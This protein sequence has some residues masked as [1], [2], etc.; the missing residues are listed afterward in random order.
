MKC[1]IT[2]LSLLV[3]L[4]FAI[5][6]IPS[7]YT[8]GHDVLWIDP[9]V[10]VT[11]NQFHKSSQYTL[12]SPKNGTSEGIA[13]ASIVGGA[14][15]RAHDT[16]FKQNFVPWK[17]YTRMSDFEPRTGK[18]AH[19][20][21]IT[22]IELQQ[23]SSDPPNPTNSKAGQL[24]ESYSLSV[25]SG[26]KVSI[27]AASS[28]GLAHGL[29]TFTQLFYAHSLGG[30][31]TPLAPVSI[32]DSPKFVH[33]GL[34][35]D[36]ARNFYPVPSILRTI[37][38]LAYNKFNRLHLHI[39]DAQ[40]WPLEVPALPEL[41]A[42]GA[43]NPS[44]IYHPDDIAEMQ[45]FGALRG[46]QVYLETDMPGHTSS[47]AY[48]Y[49]SLIAAFNIQPNWSS[50]AVEPPSG[51]LKLNSPAVDQFIEKLFADILPRVSASTP[52]FH[53]GGD[54]VDYA[55][56]EL[57]PTVKSSDPALLKPLLQKFVNAAHSHVRAAGLI[58]MAW[59][60]I[61]L[62]YNLTLGKDV[63]VQSWVSA[64]SVAQ[65]TEKGYKVIAGSSDYWYLDCGHGQF[66]NFE[67]G[68]VSQSSWPYTDYCD[69]FKN[70][71]VMYSYDPL[72]GITDE[73]AQKLVLGGEAHV[74]SEQID[75]TSLDS[76]IWPRLGAA[77]EVLWSGAKDPVTGQN[78]SQI[79][80][81]PRLSE[82]RER[83]IARGVNSGVI[84]MPFCTQ[85]SEQ[86]NEVN[87]VASS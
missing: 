33:R 35:L 25:T 37:D 26:G 45:R 46:V 23:K 83:L 16:I 15:L 43:Y 20:N 3:P 2:C 24:D 32:T 72:Q 86:C 81:A 40:S 6:P 4:A 10:K 1:I 54:E 74:W 5:W 76:T 53:T 36:V 12:A 50:V 14:V 66:V 63:V 59:E 22:S 9:D 51:T 85:E 17:F 7:K 48:A 28:L 73:A 80:A 8:Y 21:S 65:I 39:T 61:L 30:S 49:P 41:T 47:I 79:T 62:S 58:P 64:S 84:Q 11:Y 34:N 13:A 87:P 60:E 71:R 42:K 56:Y 68:M 75:A 69:P 52:Y 57:D 31:Y 44:Q 18:D 78:R 38:A 55:A 77:A 67:P 70:W 27:T 82:M 19:K 29:N